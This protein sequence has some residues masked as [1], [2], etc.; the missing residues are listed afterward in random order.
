MTQSLIGAL[1]VV[2]GVDTASFDDGLSAAQSRLT[3][4]GQQM[5][6]LGGQIARVGA[7]LS[8]TVTAP[9]V[10]FGVSAT[11]AATES[12]EAFA[13]VESALASMGSAS[14][15]TAEQLKASAR[16]LQSLSTFDD[17][18][19]LRKV[20]A[21]LLTFGNVSGEVFDRAQRAAVDLSA[22][23]GQDLQSS[24]IQL[25][26]ALNDPVKGLTAL[27]RVGVSFT[28]DQ[29]ELIKSMVAAGDVAGAQA[30]ILAELERQYG[31]A[32]KA[33]RDAAPGSDTIDAYREFQETVGE[34]VLQVLPKLTDFLTRI[35]NLF[36]NLSP[37]MQ[38]AVVAA[39]AVA[40]ALGPV[41]L[42]V[43]GLVSAGGSL[44][45]LLAKIGPAFAA[46]SA[47]I[48]STVI[49]ALAA[50]G[51]AILAMLV[52]SGPIGWLALALGAIVTVWMNW[53]KIEPIVRRLYE[54]VRMWIRERL[55]AVFDWLGRKVQ[56]A[57]DFFQAL[58]DRVVGNSY[59]PDM[60]DG[61]AEEVARLDA[62]MV[63]PIRAGIAEIED[64]FASLDSRLA[65][66]FANAFADVATGV[67]S[68]GDAMRDLIRDIGRDL[69]QMY[70]TSP[71][72]NLISGAANSL[73][74]GFFADGG[75]IPR[76]SWGIVGERG[77]EM[78]Y[79]GARGVRVE[80]M[81]RVASVPAA[82]GVTIHFHGP[83]SNAEQVRRSAA[84]AGAALLR[85]Q[86][87][88]KRGV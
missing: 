56:E 31:G 82:G 84:Q 53:D 54:A 60:V 75:L 48:T 40:A 11:R 86:A 47:V 43:G 35:L 81:A 19:I 62:V 65:D 70:V 45:I 79:A 64:G 83:V 7:G 67:R 18:E 23:L 13:Q 8:A 51:R 33:A 24:A 20:T 26:K 29:Q 77:P 49:P 85:M 21:N 2:L 15:R 46:I 66:G 44:L 14:G 72:R 52:S 5:Q 9:L 68:V 38:R 57:G 58:Y 80:P 6:Q 59:V 50:V 88:G 74:A 63:R 16:E 76:G 27:S 12:R 39:A 41:L 10:A 69:I 4:T 71:L 28:R 55:G 22:R 42:A 30:I 32:A 73:F 36:N 34:L 61:I 78:V 3:K 17:D 1:R 25:G 87:A 37:E